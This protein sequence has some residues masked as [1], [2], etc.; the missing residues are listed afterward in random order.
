MI[1]PLSSVRLAGVRERAFTLIELLVVIAIIGVLTGA[2][3]PALAA[4]RGQARLSTCLSNLRQIA[5]GVSIYADASEEVLPVAEFSESYGLAHGTYIHEAIEPYLDCEKLF[6]C[7]TLTAV[8]GEN[9]HSY[10]YLCLHAWESM[11]FDNDAQ[12]V[13]G[14]PLS[15]FRKPAGKPMVFCD[16]LGCHVGMADSEVLPQSWGGQ[17]R[18]GGMATCFADGHVQ[19]VRLN[20][21]GII[22]LYQSPR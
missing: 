2:L 19:F 8:A 5:V 15:R 13:C 7:P 14:Q 10:A 21:D 3:M 9:P 20:G 12:G 4:A 22:A 18:V 17:N 1:D 6:Q 11:G 16:S